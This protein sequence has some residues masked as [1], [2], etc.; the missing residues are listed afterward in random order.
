MVASRI[1]SA[2]RRQNV[3][4]SVEK[5]GNFAK[6][7]DFGHMTVP[8]PVFCQI[9]LGDHTAS[10]RS[11]VPR[12]TMWKSLAYV[13]GRYFAKLLVCLGRRIQ[14]SSCQAQSQVIPIAS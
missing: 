5:R 10:W 14:W 6:Q 3:M 13:L 9:E 12:L 8:N 2:G 1:I 4:K 11:R 7:L